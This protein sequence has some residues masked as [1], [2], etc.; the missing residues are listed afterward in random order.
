MSRA[1]IVALLIAAEI[2]IV[3][4]AIYTVSGSGATFASGMHHVAFSAVPIE[5][6]DAGGTPNV[7]IDDHASKVNVGLSGDGRVHV[8]DLTQM[9]GAIYSSGPYPQLS[10]TRT[11]DGVHIERPGTPRL[12]IALFGYDNEEIE[13]EVPSGSHV[14]IAHCSGAEI[15]GVAGGVTVSSQD[16]R[17]KLSDLSGNVDARSDD[18][19]IIASNVKT[20]RLSMESAD[21]RIILLNVSTGSL[22]AR[23]HDGRIEAS[24]LS[25][26]GTQPDATLHTD[27]GPLHVA[28][29]FAPNGSYELSTNDGSIELHVAQDA[30]LAITA[31]T[32]DGHVTV[33]GS[34]Q[35]HGDSTQRTI[36]LGS[37]SGTMKLA[38]ADGSIHILTNGALEQ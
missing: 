6:I 20:D 5:P 12:S 31:S 37:G 22:V 4:M 29:T 2:L 28:G 27:D 18:G 36:R 10:V 9:H 11:G 26:T 34:A 15:D 3:G 19:R 35:A 13:V 16:G 33:D 23:T 32:G 8:R 7:V 17:I 14:Q 21:G 24:G 38:T 30:D 25:V 1:S